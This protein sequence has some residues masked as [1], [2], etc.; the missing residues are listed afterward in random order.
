LKL[1][2]GIAVRGIGRTAAGG[3]LAAKYRAKSTKP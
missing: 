2:T 1:D 3:G